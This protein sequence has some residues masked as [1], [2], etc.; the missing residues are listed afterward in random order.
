LTLLKDNK[1]LIYIFAL[2]QIYRD[3]RRELNME[4]RDIKV[5]FVDLQEETD[6]TVREMKNRESLYEG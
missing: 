4:T 2:E 1:A 5:L 3:Q 6:E